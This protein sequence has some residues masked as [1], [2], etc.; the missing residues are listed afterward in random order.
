MQLN[1]KTTAEAVTTVERGG[2]VNGKEFIQNEKQIDS[3]EKY[4]GKKYKRTLTA[5]KYMFRTLGCNW[6]NK[7][8]VREDIKTL[9]HVP[10]YAY[11]RIHLEG[12]PPP[13]FIFDFLMGV[14]ASLVQPDISKKGKM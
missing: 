9:L 1:V 8:S 14:R 10:V 4:R 2:R 7:A 12:P 3:Y 11:L 6:L 13:N 5:V